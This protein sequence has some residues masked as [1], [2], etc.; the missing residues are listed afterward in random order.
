[1]VYVDEA[2]DHNLS[3]IDSNFP[4]FV[5]A[6]CIFEKTQYINQTT[7]KLQQFKFTYFGHDMTILHEREIRKSIAPFNILQNA[8]VRQSFITELSQIIAEAPFTLV[9]SCR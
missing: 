8:K 4:V 7:P 5:L 1:M 6:F 9:A 2:G 3:H